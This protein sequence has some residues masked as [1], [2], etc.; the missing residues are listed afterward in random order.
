MHAA[1]LR[2][3]RIGDR[4]RNIEVRIFAGRTEAGRH[5]ADDCVAQTAQ[6]YLTSNYTAVGVELLLPELVTQHDEALAAEAILSRLDDPTERGLRA[7][8]LEEIGCDQSAERL[9]GGPR[10]LDH[11]HSTAGV[12]AARWMER[13]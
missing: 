11:S 2:S 5:N 12:M 1:E 6:W 13:G 3:Q 7:K 8:N 4:K 9:D 10:R